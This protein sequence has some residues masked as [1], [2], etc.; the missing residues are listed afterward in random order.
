VKERLLGER[1]KL[2]RQQQRLIGCIYLRLKTHLSWFIVS[3]R[4]GP[5]NNSQVRGCHEADRAEPSIRQW[6]YEHISKVAAQARDKARDEH[7]WTRGRWQGRVQPSSRRNTTTT[8]PT[9]AAYRLLPSINCRIWNRQI[10]R[11]LYQVLYCC[12]NLVCACLCYLDPTT[13]RSPSA[14]FES[15]AA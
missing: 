1:S 9:T 5:W 4:H 3:R 10:L 13:C 14:M 7:E 15:T 6:C 8:T 11:A 12:T 2:D